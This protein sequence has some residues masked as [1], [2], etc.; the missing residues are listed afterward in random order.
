MRSLLPLSFFA[1]LTLHGHAQIAETDP[2]HAE[3]LRL[4]SLLF[5]V[6]FNNCEVEILYELTDDDFEFYHDQSGITRGQEPFVESIR[7]NICGLE[8]RPLRKLVAGSTEVFPLYEN[9]E[10]YGAVQRGEHEF[11]AREADKEPYLTSTAMFTHLWIKKGDQWII[12]RVLSYD[13]Q[14]SGQ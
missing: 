10:L 9:G 4:D 5:E 13:H 2:L 11:Y 8:Y 7:N 12:R 6:S 14:S 3:I 1:M